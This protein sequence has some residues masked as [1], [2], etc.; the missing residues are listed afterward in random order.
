MSENENFGEF[1]VFEYVAYD[2]K[3]CDIIISFLGEDPVVPTLPSTRN[4]MLTTSTIISSVSLM[5]HF[6]PLD[7]LQSIAR[8]SVDFKIESKQKSPVYFG[9]VL[10][11]IEKVLE[12]HSN[13]LAYIEGGY[14]SLGRITNMVRHLDRPTYELYDIA[15]S[16]V[17]NVV[18]DNPYFNSI[19]VVNLSLCLTN[20]MLGQV[21]LYINTYP[22]FEG[23]I[24]QVPGH[25]EWHDPATEDIIDAI[26]C[27]IMLMDTGMNEYDAYGM[28]R[29]ILLVLMS[30][31]DP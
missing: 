28:S 11:A 7:V 26:Y 5:W 19:R 1:Y 15:V 3:I 30:I 18:Y 9:D 10:F 29:R 23:D 13:Y 8:Y 24:D 25:H 14:A 21:D 22:H 6:C 31:M 27:I 17:N 12:T 2:E 20:I 4:Q 16:V